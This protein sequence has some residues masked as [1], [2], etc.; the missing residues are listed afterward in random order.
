VVQ[1]EEER[2]KSRASYRNEISD[3]NQE[4]FLALLDTK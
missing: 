4:I 1:K 3:R 2:G